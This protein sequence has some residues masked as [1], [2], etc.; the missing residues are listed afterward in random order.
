MPSTGIV[1]FFNAAKGFGFISAQEGSQDVF[2][3]ISEVERAAFSTLT[4]NQRVSFEVQRGRT[5][6]TPP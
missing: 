6:N 2:V 5:G 3:H 1:K 4:D